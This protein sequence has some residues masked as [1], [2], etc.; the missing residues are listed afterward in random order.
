M[1]LQFCSGKDWLAEGSAQL[2]LR[3]RFEV[4]TP[5]GPSVFKCFSIQL[6][7]DEVLHDDEN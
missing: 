1:E 2:R 5:I 7:L 3:V 6:I 4:Q